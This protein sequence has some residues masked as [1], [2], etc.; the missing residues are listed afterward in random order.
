MFNININHTGSN[1]ENDIFKY[2]YFDND[3]LSMSP[4]FFLHAIGDPMTRDPNKLIKKASFIC[5]PSLS[6]R[7]TRRKYTVTLIIRPLLTRSALTKLVLFP[8]LLGNNIILG[9][10]RPRRSYDHHIWAYFQGY[11]RQFSGNFY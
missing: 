3:L 9:F 11:A 7:T 10:H 2:Y 5:T 8:S 6:E 1:W 4:R